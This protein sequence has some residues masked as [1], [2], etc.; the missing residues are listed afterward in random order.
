VFG[1][2][3]V[4]RIAYRASGLP[5]VHPEDAELGLPPGRHSHGLRKRIAAEV[6]R[7]S[8]GSAAAAVAPA[9]TS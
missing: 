5:N 4:T 8:F 2:V 1:L 9:A 3:T 6:A 7:G